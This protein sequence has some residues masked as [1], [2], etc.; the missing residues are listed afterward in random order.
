MKRAPLKYTNKRDKFRGVIDCMSSYDC[1]QPSY[2]AYV[3]GL[4]DIA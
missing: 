2:Y 1:P 4:A 3:T